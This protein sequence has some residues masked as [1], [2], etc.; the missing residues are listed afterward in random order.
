MNPA[1]RIILA[2]IAVAFVH[3]ALAS[4][5][6]KNAAARVLGE[7][8]RNAFYRPFYIAQST[9]SFGGLLAYIGRQPNRVLWH[10]GKRS[11]VLLN[12][13]RLAALGGM[14]TAVRQ[15]GL[16]RLTGFRGITEWCR[17]QKVV[18]REPEAQGPALDPGCRV[19]GPFRYSRHP[20][21]FLGLPLI[22]LTPRLTRN[23][24]VF[25]LAGTLY[26]VIGSWHE[27][28]RLRQAYR[29]KY[30]DYRAG[31]AFFLGRNRLR[32]LSSRPSNPGPAH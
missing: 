19:S 7:R 31:T 16:D 3:S 6:A 14:V 8:N 2:T 29:E 23:R 17:G 30:D 22:W 5:P 21:N 24:L 20:L 25:N 15:I 11:A 10:L 4:R 28:H 1:T 32:R 18:S 13:C 27:E 9:L 26:L 12:F